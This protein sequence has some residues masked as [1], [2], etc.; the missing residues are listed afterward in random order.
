[1]R[2]V[3]DQ[4]AAVLGSVGPVAPLDVVLADAAGCVLAEDLTAERDL[5][6]VA[7]AGCDGYALRTVDLAPNA[8]G[9]AEARLP[10]VA[11]ARTTSPGPV[12]LVPGTADRK[13][14]V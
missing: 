14:V 4:L 10:V 3:S 5:P 1:M 7:L 13:S 2:S 11:D 12:R 6:P 9:A 8:Q